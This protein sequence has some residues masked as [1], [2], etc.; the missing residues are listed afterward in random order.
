VGRALVATGERRLQALGARRISLYAVPGHQPAM[1][2]WRA[3]GYELDHD[4]RF[5]RELE[6]PQ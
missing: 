2:F 4:L 3:L 1:A 6:T 5:V